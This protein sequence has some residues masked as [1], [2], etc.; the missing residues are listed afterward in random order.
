MTRKAQRKEAVNSVTTLSRAQL[1]RFL[2]Q[3]QQERKTEMNPHV[4][5]PVLTTR[6]FTVQ[7]VMRFFQE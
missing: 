3:K 5:F 6:L 4:R 2:T 1:I 7:Y